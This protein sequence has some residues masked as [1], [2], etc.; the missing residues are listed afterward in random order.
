ML[1]G[2]Y[3]WSMVSCFEHRCTAAA[4]AAVFALFLVSLL[5]CSLSILSQSGDIGAA[6]E[7]RLASQLQLRK[8]FRA[9]SQR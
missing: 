4:V 6:G 9:V 2:G 5:L 7:V 8:L 3:D 1:E